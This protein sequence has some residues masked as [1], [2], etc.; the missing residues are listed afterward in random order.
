MNPVPITSIYASILGLILIQLSLRV[1]KERR[2]HSVSLGDGGH[3]GLL[4][5]QRAHGNFVEY[6][7]MA[8]LLIALLEL[9]RHSSGLLHGLGVAL[10]IARVLHPLG[11][12]PAFGIRPPRAGGFVLTLVVV[13]VASL[14]LLWAA[15][16]GA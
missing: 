2:A 12:S 1:V 5:A 16:S 8:L 15:I 4:V 14:V 9:G 3:E 6:V 7:P 10:V 11:L 13:L